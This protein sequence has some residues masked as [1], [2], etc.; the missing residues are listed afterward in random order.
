MDKPKAPC[1]QS[2]NFDRR[3]ALIRMLQVGV[4][5]AGAAILTS[6]SVE[7]EAEAKRMPPPISPQR[8]LVSLEVE[9]PGGGAF[10]TFLSGR[11]PWLAGVEGQRYALRIQNHSN[12]RVEV[13]V[14]VDGRDVI[15]GRLGDYVKQRGY[16]LDP[17]AS[18]RIA[19]YRQ[20]LDKVAAFRF[21]DLED[22]YSARLGT[23][24][25]TGVIGLA[26]FAERGPLVRRR[27]PLA[28][29]EGEP[30]PGERADESRTPNSLVHGSDKTRGARSRKKAPS[31]TS[32]TASPTVGGARGESWAAPER[33]PQLGTEYGESTFAPVEEV[34]FTRKHRKKPDQLLV[35]RYDSMAGLRARGIVAREP[36]PWREPRPISRP[37]PEP[38]RD[39]APPPP[40]KD[41][42][43]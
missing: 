8:A 38:R 32:P 40:P 34:R 20:S 2:P 31:P 7:G 28:P 19:G 42:W 12:Q 1:H 29:V 9:G 43:R 11:Q 5:V 36:E 25:N 39:F 6:G 27:N 30:F 3:A 21:A 16:V 37:R 14:T 22:S 10:P 15:S 33:T 18:L 23:P 13:V 41:W 4:G 17:F 26:A 24:E 35:L